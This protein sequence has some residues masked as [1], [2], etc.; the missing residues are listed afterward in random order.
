MGTN[1][2]VRKNHCKCCNRHDREYHIGKSSHGWSFSSQGY[3]WNRL[4]SWK[5][6]KEFLKNEVIVDEYG[7]VVPYDDFVKMVETYKSPGFVRE[8][9]HK[10]LN[11]Y[12]YCKDNGYS[13]ERDWVDGDGYSFTVSEFS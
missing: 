8:D 11:H 3:T 7:E 6:W 1:Y 10:N 2:Y 9:G 12:E 4:D 5:N 13:T